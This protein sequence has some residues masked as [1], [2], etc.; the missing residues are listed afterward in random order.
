MSTP[1]DLFTETQREVFVAEV[2][3]HRKAAY[4]E[5]FADGLRQGGVVA[6]VNWI[7]EASDSWTMRGGAGVVAF[8]LSALTD[9]WP[10]AAQMLAGKVDP[11]WLTL[12]GAAVMA[13]R[14]HSIGR[15]P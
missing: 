15:K 14:A 2:A 5:G 3:R 10:Y 12:G 6:I 11:L 8:G 9:F 4:A 13:L 7:K 1:L